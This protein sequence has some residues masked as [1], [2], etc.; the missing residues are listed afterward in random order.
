MACKEV[1]FDEWWIDGKKP[2]LKALSINLNTQN[3]NGMTPF[4]LA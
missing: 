1:Q 3:E 2:I 4:D